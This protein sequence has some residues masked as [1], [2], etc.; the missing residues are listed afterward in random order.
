MV[1][2]LK[3]KI[4]L[5]LQKVENRSRKWSKTENQNKELK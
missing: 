4:K 1:N 5:I 3:Q 2:I